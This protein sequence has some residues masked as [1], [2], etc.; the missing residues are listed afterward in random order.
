MRGERETLEYETG[1][2]LFRYQLVDRGLRLFTVRTLQIAELNDGDSRIGRAT[3]GTVASLIEFLAHGLEGMHP[4]RDNVSDHRVL[5]IRTDVEL[6]ALLSLR[7]ADQDR[8]FGESF[9]PR[10]F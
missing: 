9:R 2:L 1:V 4:E 8:D 5:A 10:R 3:C 6:I 7:I